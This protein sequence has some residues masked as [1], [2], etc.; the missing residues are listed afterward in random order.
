MG[1]GPSEQ[2]IRLRE[3]AQIKYHPERPMEAYDQR[4]MLEKERQEKEVEMLERERRQRTLFQSDGAARQLP[5]EYRH[6]YALRNPDTRDLR[7]NREPRDIR[8]LKTI[9]EF[10][11]TMDAKDL[12]DPRDVRDPREVRKYR[13]IRDSRDVRNLRD[14]QDLH[15]VRDRGD[16][17]DSRGVGDVQEVR[18]FRDSRE[19]RDLR[20]IGGV[21][22]RESLEMRDVRDA[23]PTR[24][25]RDPRELSRDPRELRDPR[26]SG[27]LV[28]ARGQVPW[29]QQ[30]D[31]RAPHDPAGPPH[32][33]TSDYP[34]GSGPPYGQHPAFSHPPE[35]LP[36]P[37]HTAEPTTPGQVLPSPAQPYESPE[38][39]R[40]SLHPSHQAPPIHQP[41]QPSVRPVIQEPAPPPPQGPH[42]PETGYDRPREEFHVPPAHQ[43][44]HLLVNEI[45]RKGRLSP[46]PQAV[47][48]AQPQAH[49]PSGESV[50][51]NEFGRIFPGLGAAVSGAITSPAGLAFPSHST[52][53]DEDM[54]HET[55]TAIGRG[56]RR[57]AANDDDNRG[58][59]ESAGRETPMNHRV[60]RPKAHQH[61]QYLLDS[62]SRAAKS[63]TKLSHHHHN[64]DQAPS[65]FM[66]GDKGNTS[67][68]STLV[69]KEFSTS[70]QHYFPSS[71]APASPLQLPKVRR[72]IDSQE[73]LDSV[74]NRPRYHLGDWV[75]EMKLKTAKHHD[76][77]SP[78]PSRFGFASTP[79]PLPM[80]KIKG[81]ENCT[82]TVKIPRAHLSGIPLEEITFRRAVWGTDV[83]TDDSDVIAACIHGGW[84]RGA[85]SEEVDL[86]MIDVPPGPDHTPEAMTAPP[87]E[88]PVQVPANMDM[89]VTVVILPC[90]RKYAAT[91]R[92]GMT[93]REWGGRYNRFQSAHDGLS[94]MILSVRF[95]T[96]AEPASRLRGRG[97]R[98]R[99][100]KAM[101]QIARSRLYDISATPPNS[102]GS[103]RRNGSE[104]GKEN[105]ANGDGSLDKTINGTRVVQN[106]SGHEDT[107][108]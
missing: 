32:L 104:E 37:S 107:E 24:E 56:K 105:R 69:A 64:V 9:R 75:Y 27:D 1:H 19:L 93:S 35:R 38:R 94:F 16:I 33:R 61:H 85:W 66:K 20:D 55:K 51:K 67:V 65:P 46:L 45:N 90:L 26:D 97:R 49:G 21:V 40:L 71:K 74:A 4:L 96:S 70:N 50:I 77:D 5:L 76:P 6:P 80:D 91:T 101:E 25:M 86:D 88:G 58:D 48:G 79:M 8:D 87:R 22:M 28:N 17:R 106:G 43:R 52:R 81:K 62:P 98:E 11:D 84:V 73:V 95:A 15:D 3:D 78:G 92:F 89:H 31:R 18:D 100:R 23:R 14:V 39:Q 72:K 103:A 42:G 41:P 68:P 108:A 44:H 47:Q 12:R 59:D 102:K 60:K 99:M 30:H 7:D 10:R 36:P 54:H 29:K 34:S 63:L 2:C 13:D 57:K 53:H 82:L 83:Y